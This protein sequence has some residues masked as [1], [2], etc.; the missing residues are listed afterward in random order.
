MLNVKVHEKYERTKLR[1]QEKINS[2]IT[3][4]FNMFMSTEEATYGVHF[5][6]GSFI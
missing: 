2:M 5:K 6:I 1:E 4:Y 3:C